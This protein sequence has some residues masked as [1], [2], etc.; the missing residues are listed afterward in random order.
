MP[1]HFRP[2]DSNIFLNKQIYMLLFLLNGM[3][4]QIM[5][6]KR[7]DMERTTRSEQKEERLKRDRGGFPENIDR[8]S[9]RG[10]R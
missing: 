5:G 10:R 8:L 4:F 2:K 1:P 3:I 6:K 7:G 9:T